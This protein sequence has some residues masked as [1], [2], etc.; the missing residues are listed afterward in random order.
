MEIKVAMST[1]YHLLTDGQSENTN[2]EME[3]YI[4][5]YVN[6]LQNDRD[7]L[8]PLAEFGCNDGVSTSKIVAPFYANFCLHPCLGSEPL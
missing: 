3:R 4:R 1:A 2:V 7:T 6:Y 5:C 8:L